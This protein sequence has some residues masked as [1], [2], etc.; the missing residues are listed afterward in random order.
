M[1]TIGIS[2]LI[3]IGFIALDYGTIQQMASLIA[4][5]KRTDREIVLRAVRAERLYRAR[6]FPSIVCAILLLILPW[7]RK[8]DLGLL[9]VLIALFGL[10]Y[11]LL[12]ALG[13]MRIVR[14]IR[15]NSG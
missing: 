6:L 7:V 2:A 12:Q 9:A 13:L 5:T 11:F 10:A 8:V 14:N 4:H 1:T 15:R 3:L